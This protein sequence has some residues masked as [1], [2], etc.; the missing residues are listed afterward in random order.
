MKKLNFHSG[1]LT[2]QWLFSHG[3]MNGCRSVSYYRINFAFLCQHHARL[4]EAP[5][6]GHANRLFLAINVNHC[7]FYGGSLSCLAFFGNHVQNLLDILKARYSSVRQEFCPAPFCRGYF[8]C[9][10]RFQVQDFLLR[11]TFVFITN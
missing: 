4:S 6:I 9:K 8:E 11:G 2:C 3:A 5:T 10:R 1:P 7:L